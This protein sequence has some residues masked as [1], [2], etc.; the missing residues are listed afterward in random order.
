MSIVEFI[1]GIK[2]IINKLKLPVETDNLIV[3]TSLKDI[4]S[5]NSK[6]ECIDCIG[7]YEIFEWGFGNIEIRTTKYDEW[8]FIVR[9]SDEVLAISNIG[10]DHFISLLMKKKKSD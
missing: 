5:F 1:S 10:V 3:T 2:I 9:P 6:G 4:K 8:V 7:P